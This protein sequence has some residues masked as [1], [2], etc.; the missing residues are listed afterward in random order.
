MTMVRY[1][2]FLKVFFNFNII[3]TLMGLVYTY[4]IDHTYQEDFIHLGIMVIVL[5]LNGRML[6]YQKKVGIIKRGDYSRSGLYSLLQAIFIHIIF[7]NMIL[8]WMDMIT[9]YFSLK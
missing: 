6:R 1:I 9:K 4:F 8:A 2:N 3:S 5:R 7:I